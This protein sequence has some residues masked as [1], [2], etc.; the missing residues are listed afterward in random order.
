MAGKHHEVRRLNVSGV[1]F[2]DTSSRG[3]NKSLSN[4]DSKRQKDKEAV[5]IMIAN[6]KVVKETEEF[7]LPQLLNGLR[8]GGI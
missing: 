4:E 5:Q 2:T 7:G 8:K 1:D 3:K 6:H